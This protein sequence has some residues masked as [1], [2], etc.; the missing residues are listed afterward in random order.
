MV[1][2]LKAHAEVER[3]MKSDSTEQKGS[4]G[5]TIQLCDFRQERVV[6][7]AL[8][9]SCPSGRDFVKQK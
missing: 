5:L 1:L 9:L 2:G 3:T 6:L 8:I 7:R 4:S